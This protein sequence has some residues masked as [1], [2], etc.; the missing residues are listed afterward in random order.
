MFRLDLF[1]SMIL[2]M[3]RNLRVGYLSVSSRAP[4]CVCVYVVVV[5][6]GEGADGDF[7]SKKVGR[8]LPGARDP[9][10]FPDTTETPFQTKVR[11]IHRNFV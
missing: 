7:L 4:G 3:P 11:H 5:G 6:E 2:S 9:S 8:V 1:R 10:P